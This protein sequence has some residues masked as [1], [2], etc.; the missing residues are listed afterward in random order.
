MTG[1][2]RRRG[3]M[4]LSDLVNVV[5]CRVRCDVLV[6]A[7]IWPSSKVCITVSCLES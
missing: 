4:I 1:I 6:Y 7:I 5:D 2:H 3:E